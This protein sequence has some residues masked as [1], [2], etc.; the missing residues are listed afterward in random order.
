MVL[1]YFYCYINNYF[2]LFIKEKRIKMTA[3]K[4][5][6]KVIDKE[7]WRQGNIPPLSTTLLSQMASSRQL[8]SLILLISTLLTFFFTSPS[9]SSSDVFSGVSV[10]SV[11]PNRVTLSVYYETLCPYCSNFIVRDLLKIF[12]NGLIS[13][14][15]LRMI[16]WGNA[17]LRPDKTFQCQV[18]FPHLHLGILCFSAF[19]L[20]ILHL[21]AK[22]TEE[23]KNQH[24]GVLR[25]YVDLL[26][27]PFPH[28]PQ[29]RRIFLCFLAY[30]TTKQ[31]QLRS[32]LKHLNFKFDTDC[33]FFVLLLGLYNIFAAWPCWMRT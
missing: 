25:F 13:I 17:V 29:K 15:N 16:P 12:E 24:L 22:K 8:L 14:V 21:V 10:S 6:E 3:E 23:N 27:L 4:E 11:D 1:F 20:Y 5:K 9:H 31:K 28:P 18:T 7:E 32:T 33:N 30:Q 26:S 19:K 2:Y